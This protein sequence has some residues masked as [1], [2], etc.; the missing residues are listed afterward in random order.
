MQEPFVIDASVETWKTSFLRRLVNLSHVVIVRPD[1]S[2]QKTAA[3][4]MNGVL[5]VAVVVVVAVAVAVVVVVDVAV[6][7]LVV[8]NQFVHP[9]VL[10]SHDLGIPLHEL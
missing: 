7:V 1:L 6:V 10:L 9:P 4:L 2:Q 5:S 8:M 3:A